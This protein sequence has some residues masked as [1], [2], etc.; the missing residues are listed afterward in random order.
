MASKEQLII[1][2]DAGGDPDDALAIAVA[3]QLPN[4]AAFITSDET[5]GGERARYVQQLV[6]EAGADIP[7]YTGIVSPYPG[8][9][10]FEHMPAPSI[11]Q[12]QRI[13]RQ[14]M[15]LLDGPLAWI[16]LGPYTN[17]QFVLMAKPELRTS[18]DFRAVLMGG[19]LPHDT[20]ERA[21]HNV[22][23]D[24]EAA[25]YVTEHCSDV[26]FVPATVTGVES[27]SVTATHAIIGML[28]A[29]G[30]S[31][32]VNNFETWFAHRY[33]QSFQHDMLTLGIGYGAV[34]FAFWEHVSVSGSRLR[35]DEASP[36]LAVKDGVDYDK[37]W[38]WAKQLLQ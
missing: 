14:F 36:V 23:V 6:N 24:P 29:R 33:P 11:A 7:V 20:V 18:E 34:D 2:T 38:A 8:K 17:L 27:M 31:S 28:Q 22:K 4:V 1:D 25:V 3:C 19:R 26:L 15:K 16:G 37:A 32:A 35:A 12:P 5:P 13:G 10:I 30:F 9:S 21:E